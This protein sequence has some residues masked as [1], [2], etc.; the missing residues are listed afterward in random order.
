MAQRAHEEP[1]RGRAGTRELRRRQLIEAT[2]DSIAKRGFAETKMADVAEGAGLS[3]GIV[4][5]HFKSKDTLFEETLRFLAEE[6]RESWK[7]ALAKAGDDP[8]ERLAAMIRNDFDPKVCNRKKIAVW[9]AFWGEAKSR[10]TYLALCDA[11]DQ[12]FNAEMTRLCALLI[13]QGEYQ[14]RD[15]GQLAD[16]LCALTNGLW[17]DFLISPR[18]ISRSSAKQICLAFLAMIFPLHFRAPRAHAA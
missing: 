4:N 14:N 12:E 10:P 16:G 7:A 18:S 8:A 9:Y 5:F 2:I 1:K 11:G 15:P 17:Q 13:E 3:Q 6:Y